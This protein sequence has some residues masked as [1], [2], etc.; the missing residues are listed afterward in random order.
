MTKNIV[1]PTRIGDIVRLISGGPDMTVTGFEDQHNAALTS[2]AAATKATVSWIGEGG[3][4]YTERFPIAALSVFAAGDLPPD[5]PPASEQVVSA[6]SYRQ[7]P[8]AYIA[9]Q[10]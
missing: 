5:A 7:D 2:G 4:P 1:A 8:E 10:E 3:A 9:R 6:A